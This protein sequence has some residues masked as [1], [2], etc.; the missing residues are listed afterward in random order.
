M[1]DKAGPKPLTIEEYQKRISGKKTLIEEPTPRP[2]KPKRRGGVTTA[3]RRRKANLLR[4]I[5]SD[6]P[7]SWAA[8]TELW[9]QVDNIE[10]KLKF[11][12]TQKKT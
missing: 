9:L 5:N 4:V 8:S 11:L 2:H 10:K 6:P 3:L 1:S 12:L 7:P